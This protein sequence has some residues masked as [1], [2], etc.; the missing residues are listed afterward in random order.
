MN[1]PLIKRFSL[2]HHQAVAKIL[3]GVILRSHDYIAR[4]RRHV[5][6]PRMPNLLAF[7]HPE[8]E[9]I[10]LAPS[11]ILLASL[12]GS[13]WEKSSRFWRRDFTFPSSFPSNYQEN[14]TVFVQTYAN[15][16]GFHFPAVVVLHGLMSLSLIA[17]RPFFRAVIDAGASAYAL[18]LPHH[19]RRTPPGFISGEL[20]FTAN[21]EMS[22]MTMQQAMADVRQLIHYLHEAGAPV[23]G[24]LG[25]SLGA[26]I[27]ALVASCEP[28]VDFALLALLPSSINELIWQTRLGQPL[29]RQF[30][31]AGWD[32]A[33]TAPVYQLL[34]PQN[35][36]PLL[37]VERLELFAAQ[38][39]HFIPMQ[40]IQALHECWHKPRLRV[41]PHGHIS[42][43]FSG[44]FKRDVGRV[45]TKQIALGRHQNNK[46]TVVAEEMR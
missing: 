28:K 41:Y 17:Y 13:K 44:K 21:L 40:H 34:D 3:D 8:G 39:D 15:A 7:P 20:F 36:S 31:S 32:A 11:S 22:W 5:I 18:E 2:R 6:H 14:R 35:F 10:F 1:T 23:I 19:L 27:A 33:T 42:L 16:S 24:L 26:W 30:Q 9:D 37:P 4:R 12:D 29:R 38:F 25:F 43:M 46:A 45:L